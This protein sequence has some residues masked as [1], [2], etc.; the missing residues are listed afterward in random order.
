MTKT[1]LTPLAKR[2]LGAA[3]A[4]LDAY[5]RVLALQPRSKVPDT[6]FCPNG[7]DSATDDRKTVRAWLRE[8]PSINLGAVMKGSPILVI[9]VD[10]PAGEAALKG[11]GSLPDTRETQTRDGRHLYFRHDGKIK[12]SKIGLEPKL[13][14]IASGYVVLPESSHPE[15]GRYKSDDVDAPIAKLPGKVAKAILA[16]RKPKKAAKPDNGS[17]REG[18]RDNRLT[19]LAGS[20][21]RQGFDDAVITTALHAVNDEHCKPPLPD[22]DIE[23]IASSVM[24]YDPADD[25]LFDS[26]ANVTPR[27]VDFLVEPYFVRGAINLLEGDPNVGKT[28]LL[29]ELA[30][31]ISSGRALPGQTKSKPGNVL[32][33]SAED[34]PETTLVKRLMRMDADLSRITFSK[35]FFRLEEEALGWIER[36]IVEKQAALLILDPLLAYMQGGIDMNK[37]NETRPFMARLAELAKATNVTVIAL[38]HLTKGEKDKAI[39]RG[40]GSVDIT[41]AAR[42]AVLIGQHPEND[43][44]RVMVHIKHN[45]SERGPS[46]LYALVDGDR[47]K[48]IIPRVAWQGEC[49]L[50][51]EDF[52]KSSEK[53][54]R[55]DTEVKAAVEF[56]ETALAKGERRIKDV[57]AD[58]EKR[59]HS[60]RTV[61]RAAK[62]LGVVK[63]GQSWKLANIIL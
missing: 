10:G 22:K 19:S 8:D 16:Y 63:T 47:D 52:L 55:P 26:M 38:R 18:S 9:D 12:G 34:D 11:F 24:R 3:F 5:M 51:P 14:I 20:F 28:Y 1:K 4:A 21:R 61:R 15:G 50:G 31:A 25:E 29:C 13:D 59:S 39:F 33:M 6:R 62:Q 49:E 53:V 35:K 17:L 42:S 27:D 56:L 41:A 36:H 43:E 48:R 58:G 30:A 60:A 37:A 54:G 2:K 23:R 57:I 46:Q 40:L 44:L 45:L 7:A 32:F